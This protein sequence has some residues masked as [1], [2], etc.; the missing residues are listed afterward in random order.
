VKTKIDLYGPPT[1]FL[2]GVRDETDY[3]RT[4]GQVSQGC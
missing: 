2:Y 1:Q 3:A 4:S